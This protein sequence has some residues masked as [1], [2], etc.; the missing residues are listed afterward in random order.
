MQVQAPLM[1]LSFPLE[2]DPVLHA[3]PLGC[4]TSV[5]HTLE[6]PEQCSASSQSFAAVRHTYELGRKLQPSQQAPLVHLH[7][8]V[9][10]QVHTPPTHTV[11]PLVQ[12]TPLHDVPLGAFLSSGHRVEVPVQY[13]AISQPP[14]AERHLYVLGRKKQ[15]SQQAP[16][17]HLQS[18]TQVHTPATHLLLP[19]V[20]VV[21]LQEVPLTA[22]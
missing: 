21:P 11:F 6:D 7:V 2:Q 10:T 4:F 20:Q 9:A 3:V 15:P 19:L 17:V 22:F 13:S 1:H 14:D 18:R 5:G 12:E 16:L 8:A